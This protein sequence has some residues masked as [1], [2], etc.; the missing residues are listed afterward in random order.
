MIG[1]GE[2]DERSAC[3]ADIDKVDKYLQRIG[4]VIV[5]VKIAGMQRTRM[6][7]I[8]DHRNATKARNVAQKV[9]RNSKDAG[10][11]C[12]RQQFGDLNERVGKGD[13]FLAGGKVAVAQPRQTAAL[14][15]LNRIGM[16][17]VD[18]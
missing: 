10:I 8:A 14:A 6:R 12:Q 4:L 2:V 9:R 17:K 13:H 3:V 18:L 7:K 15:G 1:A 5:F 16:R 11:K